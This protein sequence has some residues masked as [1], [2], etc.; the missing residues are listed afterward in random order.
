MSD[1]PM[2]TD[3]EYA[4]VSGLAVKQVA[5]EKE[6]VKL[7]EDLE[8][9]QAELNKVRDH[10]L[11]NALMEV[12]LSEVTLKSGHKIS[13]KREAYVSITEER[14]DECFAWLRK[15]GHG[16]IIKNLIFAEFGKGEDENA[17]EAA[18]ALADAGFKPQQKESVHPMT[19]KAFVKEVEEKMA[20]QGK[21]FPHEMFGSFIVN[22][23]KVTK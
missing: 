18:K 17:I 13:I 12:G 11:P 8:K 19:L 6:L 15:N 7:V 9:K 1:Q 23:S 16:A 10:D 14:K 2:I 22:R 21:E 20:E 4:M 5:L 3:A